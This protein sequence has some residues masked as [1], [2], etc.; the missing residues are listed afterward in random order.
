MK[1]EDRSPSSVRETERQKDTERQRQ[2]PAEIET[3]RER[4]GSEQILLLHIFVV[5]KPSVD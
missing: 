1:A 5:F 2:K 3:H 4:Q